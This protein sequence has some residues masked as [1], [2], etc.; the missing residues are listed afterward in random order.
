MGVVM[1]G[2]QVVS[3]RPH[4][5]VLYRHRIGAVC[6]FL[7]GLGVTA[8]TLLILPNVFVSSTVVL[9]Q[10]QTVEAGNVPSARPDDVATRVSALTDQ[11][12]RRVRLEEIIHQLDLYPRAQAAAVPIDLIADRMRGHVEIEMNSRDDRDAPRPTSFKLTFEYPDRELVQQATAMMA[13]TYIDED[14]Q[15]RSRQADAASQFLGE[16]V[17]SAQAK[18]QQKADEIKAYKNRHRG[19]L[20]EEMENSFRQLDL[21]Q[22]Q[23][24][25]LDQ[26]L[27]S[28]KQ[29]S[30]PTRLQQLETQL[31]TLR[32]QFSDSY[33]DVRSLR[34]QIEALKK[35]QSEAGAGAQNPPGQSANGPDTE[36]LSAQKQALEGQ[37]ERIREQIAETPTREQELAVMNR[38]YDV[39]TKDYEQLLHKQLDAQVS[40]RLERSPD[41]A[42][43][44]ILEPAE[45]PLLPVRPNRFAILL[46]GLVFSTAA[47]LGLPFALFFTDTSFKDPDE[48][49]SEY[50]LPVLVAIP[51]VEEAAAGGEFRS[52]LLRALTASGVTLTVALAAVWV[53]ATRFF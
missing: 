18:V 20:P 47:A 45:L 9:V 23:L 30:A 8:F 37:M 33:P 2:L 43:L 46:C 4:L 36:S 48:L 32:A 24:N 6:A 14:L 3:L 34:A 16:Q 52:S 27:N 7:V 19:A 53:Y 41:S 51:E 31:T 40:A 35:A 21:L 39:V 42:H 25:N 10:L 12:L 22:A 1:G 26:S 44:K 15:E 29:I 38:E 17:S 49:G 5:D 50:G 11:A 28:A 13:Q